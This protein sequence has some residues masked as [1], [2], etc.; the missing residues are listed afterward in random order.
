RESNPP[1]RASRTCSRVGTREGR[2]PAVNFTEF[3]FVILLVCVYAAWWLARGRYPLQ[4]AVLLIG[5][6]VFYGY[7]RWEYLLVILGYCVVDGGV[8][9]ATARP[10]WPR[11]M[12]SVGVGLNLA[13]LC[14]YKYTPMLLRT[15]ARAALALDWDSAPSVPESWIIPA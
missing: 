12:L 4:M 1:R 7:H 13:V 15:I 2:R 5:S 9:L 14:F 6:L 3:G 10:A 8:G 11:L